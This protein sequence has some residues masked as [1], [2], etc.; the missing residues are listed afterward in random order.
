[1][2]KKVTRIISWVLVALLI[3][4]VVSVMLYALAG[5]I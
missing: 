4:S 1:M 5:A 3:L 2:N